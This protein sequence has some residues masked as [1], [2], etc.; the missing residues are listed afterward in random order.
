MPAT[1]IKV[2]GFKLQ[3]VPKIYV[4]GISGL[5]LLK[6]TTPS[7]R[8]N[9]PEKGFQRV[10]REDRTRAIALAVLDQ[11]RTFPNAIVIATDIAD[12]A[13][14]GSTIEIPNK[15]KFLVVDGQHR[16]WAQKFSDNEAQYACVIHM[17]LSEEDMAYLFLEINDNQKRV[18]PSLRWDLVRLVRPNDDPYGIA[19]VDMIY[20][21]ASEAESPLFQRID[22]T[23]EQSEILLKQAS[24]A[25][26]IKPLFRKTLIR[27]LSFDEQY[28]LI[29]HYFIAIKELDPDNW[30]K[31]EGTFYKARVLRALLRLLPDLIE[32]K[33]KHATK[34]K[35]DDFLPYLKK[36]KPESLNT[37]EIRA[38]QGSAGIKDIYN[39]IYAQVFS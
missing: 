7:W 22:L 32:H 28:N 12:F 21:L 27:D 8:I 3:D 24:I 35:Y 14:D 13:F 38:A 36:I 15:I 29:L 33:K 6:R 23:G 18:P 20:L 2:P 39:R 10:V 26:E 34:L 4:A 31:A 17:G 30:G 25:P 19:T 9:D 11:Q 5:W 1:S 37:E 16:L